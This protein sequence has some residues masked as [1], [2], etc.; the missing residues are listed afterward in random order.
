[1]SKHVKLMCFL[2]FFILCEIQFTFLPDSYT[3]KYPTFS[4][5]QSIIQ[6]KLEKWCLWMNQ[7]GKEWQAISIWREKTI[8]FWMRS[9]IFYVCV[10]EMNCSCGRGCSHASILITSSRLTVTNLNTVCFLNNSTFKVNVSV[11]PK[12]KCSPT[13]LK[14]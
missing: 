1:M 12:R 5:K 2:P 10:G 6:Y 8:F 14:V 7:L 4:G 9:E 3:L 11:R 13:F